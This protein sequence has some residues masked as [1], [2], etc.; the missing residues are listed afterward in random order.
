[1]KLNPT[2]ALYLQLLVTIVAFGIGFPS[3]IFTRPAWLRRV[4]ERYSIFHRVHLLIVLTL[5]VIS[6]MLLGYSFR[7][8]KFF[9]VLTTHGF[10]SDRLL[11]LTN[12]SPI[13][14]NIIFLVIIIFL[15]VICF[16]FLLVYFHKIWDD[17]ERNFTLGIVVSFFLIVISSL[18]FGL[19]WDFGGVLVMLLLDGADTRHHFVWPPLLWL[20]DNPE[21]VSSVLIFISFVGAGVLWLRLYLYNFPSV[22]ERL[23]KI[24]QCRL[25]IAK[26]RYDCVS[27][28]FLKR[29]RRNLFLRSDYAELSPRDDRKF[30]SISSSIVDMGV[31]GANAR[32][33]GEKIAVL[34]MLHDLVMLMKKKEENEKK[35]GSSFLASANGLQAV[36]D[37]CIAV[38]VTTTNSAISGYE[39]V[40]RG[41]EIL[42]MLLAL[43]K[44]CPKLFKGNYLD[45]NNHVA[46]YVIEEGVELIK[47]TSRS[48]QGRLSMW[49]L[50]VAAE[51]EKNTLRNEAF[52]RFGVEAIS[53]GNVNL[54]QNALIRLHYGDGDARN[55]YIG[56]LAKIYSA[57][58]SGRDWVCNIWSRNNPVEKEWVKEAYRYFISQTGDI[59]TADAI[60]EFG[61]CLGADLTL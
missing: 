41:V 15:L 32:D 20:R 47:L 43:T 9:S 3:L 36:K 27:Y 34:R 29:V 13:V 1:M 25:S 49:L 39:G 53:R 38:D 2:V 8:E 11:K 30:E 4:R 60:R 33:Q 46:E 50:R 22:L 5:V 45:L 48:E 40:R 37:I 21:E 6:I 57:G 28:F 17:K 26:H 35:D 31:L 59:S 24:S 52:F 54:R 23:F 19:I 51:I 55:F 14:I 10:V 42:D 58:D 18:L 61:S 56:L 7:P 12:T 44:N 16:R